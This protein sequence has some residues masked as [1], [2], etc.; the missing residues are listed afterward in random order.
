MRNRERSSR[1]KQECA[2]SHTYEAGDDELGFG[3]SLGNGHTWSTIGSDGRIQ[4]LFGVD[5]GEEVAGPLMIRYASPGTHVS[6]APRVEGRSRADVPLFQSGKGRFIVHPTHHEHVFSLPGGIEGTEKVFVPRVQ[7]DM[8]GDECVVYNMV[9]LRNEAP[10]SR[11]LRVHALVRLG[12][13]RRSPTIVAEYDADRGAIFAREKEH[14]EWVRTLAS[15]HTPKNHAVTADFGALYDTDAIQ[16]PADESPDSGDVMGCLELEVSLEPGES[17]NLSFLLSF[18]DEGRAAAENQLE[19]LRD[20]DAIFEATRDYYDRELSTCRIFTPDHAINEGAFWSKVNMVRVLGHYPEGEA[21]T[22]EP[23]VSSNVVARD[24]VWFVYGCDHYRP[25]SS[26]RMLNKLAAVQYE[27]GMIPEYYNALTGECEEYGLN[28]NDATPLFVLGVNH[29]ARSTG[30]LDWLEEVYDNAAAASRYI[31][32]QRDDRGLVYCEAEGE[33]VWGICSWRNVIPNYQINGA[34]TEINAECAAALRAMAHM[35]ENVGRDEEGEWFYDRAMELT[36]AIN[37]HLLDEE[38]QLYLLNIDTDGREHTDVTADELFPVLFRVAPRDVAYRIVRRL[39]SPDFW[40]TAGLRSVS[41]LDPLY[42]PSHH[43]GLLGGVWPGVT[44]WYAFAAARYH[45]E[46]M[47]KALHASFEHYQRDPRVFTTVPG[48]FSEWFDGD[49]LVNRGMRLSPWEPPRFLWAAVEGVGGMMLS[50]GSPGINPLIPPEWKWVAAADV[51]YHGEELTWFAGRMD[52]EIHLY[53]NAEFKCDSPHT[54]FEQDV[55]GSVRTGHEG[56]HP[57]ALLEEGRILVALGTCSTETVATTVDL[58]ALLGGGETWSV[59]Q[60]SSER[61][62]WDTP[63]TARGEELQ[64]VGVRLE[65]RGYHLL[66]LRRE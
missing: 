7:A 46:F 61:G 51:P 13:G 38:R 36:D 50:P 44:W 60:Y 37:E 40:T 29:H 59:R 18:T 57:V 16:L 54:V 17:E 3:P 20:A 49:S 32:S 19:R 35:A 31:L 55:T 1:L 45:P 11:V 15:S 43:V 34:V 56:V 64:A 33:E 23:G 12:G 5:V 66:E 52:D 27:N 30:D 42:H 10:Q 28:I 22:N 24:V 2:Q 8:A 25:E 62:E 47:V 9:E 63:F 41:R 58:G 48:Q 39:N 53:A 4:T 6:S 14:E 21:F 65:A 26:R